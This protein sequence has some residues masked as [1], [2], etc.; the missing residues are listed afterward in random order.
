MVD[1]LVTAHQVGGVNQGIEPSWEGVVICFTPD[2]NRQLVA[3][4]GFLLRWASVNTLTKAINAA[5]SA[6]F[7]FGETPKIPKLTPANAP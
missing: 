2:G 4:S 6:R 3:L 1:F 7:E 5:R